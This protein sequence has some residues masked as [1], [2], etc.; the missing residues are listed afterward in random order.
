[1]IANFLSLAL[2][3]A[4]AVSAAQINYEQAPYSQ[5][6]YD[7]YNVLKHYGG[8]G[9]YSDNPGVG[10]SR[11]PPAS[12]E[13]DQVIMLMRHGERFPDPSVG[14]AMLGSLAKVQA[15][16][17][18]FKGSLSFVPDYTFF[19]PGDSWYAQET[20]TGP[21]NGLS[22]GYKTGNL[23]RERYGHLWDGESIV[24]VF[25]SGYE[26]IINTARKFG[27]GFFGYNYSTNAA[28]NIIPEDAAQGAQSLTPSCFADAAFS[29]CS[30]LPNYMPIFNDTV[31]RLKKEYPGL[32]IG[33]ADIYNLM[34][35]AAF[36]LNARKDSPWI[37]VFTLDEWYAYGY[38]QDLDYYY[39][40]GPGMS[41]GVPIGAVFANAT[42]VLLREGPKKSGSMFWNFC[43]DT[44]ITP[45]LAAL[46]IAVPSEPLPMYNPPIPHVYRSGDLVPMGGR[47]IIERLS[48][49][50]TTSYDAG[51]YIRIVVNEAVIPYAKCQDGPGYSCPLSKYLDM[52]AELPDYK[53]ACNVP[54]AYP[55]YL[56]FFW[57][58]N[59]TNT[60]NY[61]KGDIP[62]Q[63]GFASQ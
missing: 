40:A 1:M 37:D 10:I 62:Y 5:G 41:N 48:C 58:Y 2:F 13:V 25:A 53:K 60:L 38:T 54:A 35:M 26:R 4:A 12:C 57:D 11:D 45:V 55:Q 49:K 8:N 21:Y 28:L 56:S 31:A 59:T 47:L 17:S 18:S 30:E 46:G 19:V 22:N 16:N 43:H 51:S 3:S 24:P 32:N 42:S 52:I 23:Y 39:C 33:T 7:N 6:F 9:P 36:E 20:W 44:N 15:Y 14:E 34:M 63:E 61:L 27:E 50:A 29:V